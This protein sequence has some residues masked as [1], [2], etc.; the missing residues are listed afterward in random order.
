LYVNFIFMTEKTRIR[1]DVSLAVAQLT[2]EERAAAAALLAE[3][4]MG[5]LRGRRPGV[6]AAY[7]PLSDEISPLP[8]V[9]KLEAA[10]WRVVIP[11]VCGEEM[12]FYTFS[13]DSLVDGAWGIAEPLPAGCPVAA[14]GIDVMIVPGRAFTLDGSRLGRGKG[15]YDRYITRDGFA[16]R[17]V[18]VC[19]RCQLLSTLPTEPHDRKVDDV[20]AC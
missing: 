20:V 17:T 15:F 3:K 12:E 9:Q 5:L 11:K 2:E 13:E 16:A 4:L 1:K 19:F 7:M 14:D 8:L 10:G 6:M 18:G